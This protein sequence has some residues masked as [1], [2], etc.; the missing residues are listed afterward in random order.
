LE[1]TDGKQK[2]SKSLGN[3][4]GLNDNPKDMFGKIMSIPDK[5]IIKYFTL[6]TDL[7]LK[8]IDKYKSSMEK[9]EINPKEVKI[10]LGEEI[11]KSYHPGVNAGKVA[12]EFNRIFR[13]KKLPQE[14]KEAWLMPGEDYLESGEIKLVTLMTLPEIKLA[15]SN[16]KARRLIMDNA[17]SID[18]KKITDVNS[19]IRPQNGMVIKVGK[20]KFVRIRFFEGYKK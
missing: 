4:I 9:G 10:K 5:L 8:E 17:V 14:I 18:Q 15:D 13:D 16:K 6:L 20:K 1:G 2:M 11:L 7:S 3:Y 19:L 12:E